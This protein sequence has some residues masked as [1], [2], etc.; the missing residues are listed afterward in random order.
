MTDD[1][2]W[3]PAALAGLGISQAAV[4]EH[5]ESWQAELRLQMLTPPGALPV[6]LAEVE[7]RQQH[8]TKRAAHESVGDDLQMGRWTP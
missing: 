4:A 8:M 1:L 3:S 6:V 2:R 7:R 5:V